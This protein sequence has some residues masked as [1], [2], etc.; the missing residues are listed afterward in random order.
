MGID[1]CGNLKG[2]INFSMKPGTKYD[3]KKARWDLLPLRPLQEVVEVLT[4]GANE[5]GKNNWQNLKRAKSRFFSALMRHLVEYREG[6]KIDTDTGKSHLAHAVCNILFLM[7]FE[8]KSS[9][10]QR[11]RK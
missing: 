9:K 5:H 11:S 10:N 7:W 1:F 3:Q 4:A 6:N 2:E 8:I